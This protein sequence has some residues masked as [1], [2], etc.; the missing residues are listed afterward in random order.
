MQI[1][2]HQERTTRHKKLTLGAIK[3]QRHDNNV[4]LHN[5]Q[6]NKPEKSKAKPFTNP[7]F[8]PPS[9]SFP[10]LTIGFHPARVSS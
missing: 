8:S 4:A 3:T 1:L 10:Q 2:H 6:E 5:L 9:T 7:F